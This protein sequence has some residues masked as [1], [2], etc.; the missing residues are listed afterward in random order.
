MAQTEDRNLL[1]RSPLMTRRHF[2][3]G[4][5]AAGTLS[6]AAS[7][8]GCLLSK[9]EQLNVYNWSDYIGQT[10]I[11]D[12]ER[13]FGVKVNYDNYSSNDELLAKV[14]TGATGYDIIVPSDYAVQILAK[15]D[16]LEPI[17]MDRITN[18]SNIGE[19][20]RSPPFDPGPP[21]AEHKYSIPYQWGTT[22]IGYNE[23][24][25]TDQVV[26]WGI[27]WN[28]KYKG[29]ITMLREMREV[30]GTTLKFLGHSVNDTNPDHLQ[31]VKSKLLDQKP[32]VAQ[33]TTDTYMDALSSGDS[34]LSQGWSGDIYQVAADNEDVKYCIPQEG[35]IVWMDNMAILKDA[36]HKDLAHEFINYI[37]RPKVSA[38][39]SNYVWYAN[40][41]EASHQYTD[42]AIIN[43]PS[44]Y[45]SNDV[46]ARLEFL[47]ELGEYQ[48]QMSK[49]WMEIL[50]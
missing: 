14:T 37:L 31:E 7:V 6:A 22:G 4:A 40:P 48:Q 1:G 18:F 20:F 32:L 11:R 39:I 12:F 24:K 43:D 49:V 38:G 50:A 41:N 45:P 15:Q 10:T 44:I 16:L 2:V 34:W 17:E 28:D 26:G 29:R 36:P 19:K 9:K 25:V 8:G 23:A 33:Y 3:K 13:E 42:E 30:I 5:V 21:K 46:M 47:D 27:L 35:T